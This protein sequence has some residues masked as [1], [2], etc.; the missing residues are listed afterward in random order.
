MIIFNHRFLEVTYRKGKP[1][2]AYHHL[3]RWSD[4]REDASVRVEK[5]GPYLVDWSA[6]GR[7]LGIEMP[8]PSPVTVEE[9]DGVLAE[10]HLDPEEVTPSPFLTHAG[11]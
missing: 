9:L 3:S 8:F 6:G 7:P 4:A 10:L 5:H 11:A 2:A 1:F